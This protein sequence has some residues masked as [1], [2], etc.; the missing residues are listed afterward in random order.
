VVTVITRNVARAARANAAGLDGIHHHFCHLGVLAHPKVIVGTPHCDLI[1]AMPVF[2]N[3]QE[4][5]AGAWQFIEKA[6][7]A[8]LRE[9][10]QLTLEQTVKFQG[11]IL[12]S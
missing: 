5:P 12:A 9:S 2:L 10:V 4:R 7:I 6:V 1:L 8:R 11:G 3:P